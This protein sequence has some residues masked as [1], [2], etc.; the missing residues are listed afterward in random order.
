MHNESVKSEQTRAHLSSDNPNMNSLVSWL[1]L[2]R[3][4]LFSQRAK[5][6]SSLFEHWIGKTVNCI[7]KIYDVSHVS[8]NTSHF[9]KQLHSIPPH[10]I[11]TSSN[12][13]LFANAE[14]R[15]KSH[16]SPLEIPVPSPA[17]SHLAVLSSPPN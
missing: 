11:H 4:V 10:L 1:S 17:P 9:A 15:E 8:V 6:C 13:Q 14:R 7:G 3:Q 2:S 5:V 12:L 16:A